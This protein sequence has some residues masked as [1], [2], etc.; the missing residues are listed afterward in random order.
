[1]KILKSLAIYIFDIID[2]FI[3]QKRILKNLKEN[4]DEINLLID[5]G[6]HKG[7]YTDLILEN[8]NVKQAFLFEPQKNIYKFIKKK[9]KS[10]KKIKIYNNA[11]SNKAKIEKIYINKHDLTSSLTKL[12]KK[13]LYLNFKAK[14]FGTNVSEMIEGSYDIKTIKLEDLIKK[15]KLNNIDLLKIDTEGHEKEVLKGLGKKINIIKAILIEIHND[16]IYLKYSSSEINRYLLKNKFYLQKRI[17]FPFT[18]WEDR[19]YLKK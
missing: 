8:F 6:S 11:V 3:H 19:I 16:N 15:K 14:L 7:T 5:V 10:K 9:Y 17:K 1:M 12:N 18:T 2:K 4:I 13:N